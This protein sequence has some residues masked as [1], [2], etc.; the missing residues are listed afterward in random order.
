MPSRSPVKPANQASRCSSVVPVL[1]ATSVSAGRNLFRPCAGAFA[2][3]VLHRCGEQVDRLGREHLL[4]RERIARERPAFLR[5][6]VADRAQR[7]AEPAARDGLVH[8]RDLE[9]THL[10]R[11]E[12]GGGERPQRALDAEPAHVVEHAVDAEVGAQA[13]RGGVVGLRQRSPQRHHA[14]ELL[15]VVRRLPVGR[16]AALPHERPVVDRREQ[17]VLAR[18]RSAP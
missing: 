3:H 12:Q 7:R 9:G 11:A 5:G 4:D 16:A 15:V 13:R 6:H 17:G 1:P 14:V 8:L 10:H 18:A 2:H